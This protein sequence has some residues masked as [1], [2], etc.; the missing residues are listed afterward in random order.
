MFERAQKKLDQF[1][2]A[3]LWIGG[4]AMLCT[5]FLVGVEVIIRKL[6]NLS[7]GGADEISGYVFA[8]ATTW[9]YS[10]VIRKKGNVRID[11]VYNLL[12]G[13][14]KILL[15]IISFLALGALLGLIGWYGFELVKATYETGRISVTPLRT[16]LAI[17]QIAWIGGIG[18]ALLMWALIALRVAE[19]AWRRNWMVVSG[20]IGA[21]GIEGEIDAELG[22]DPPH[23]PEG[24][25]R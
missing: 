11:V 8:A 25:A 22:E 17:P 14:L 18:L 12:P 23:N 7:I 15:D 9:S 20:L 13:P 2:Q 5:A 16:P 10:A 19:N 1:S 24:S 3:A 4:A 6:F 21:E